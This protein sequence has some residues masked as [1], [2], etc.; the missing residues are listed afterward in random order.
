MF[1]PGVELKWVSQG[2]DDI[3][4]SAREEEEAWE[5]EEPPILERGRSDR[6]EDK[7]SPHQSARLTYPS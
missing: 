5:E 6:T 3:H 1:S 2:S 4:S 7:A